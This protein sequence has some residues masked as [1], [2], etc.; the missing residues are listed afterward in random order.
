MDIESVSTGFMNLELGA[1]LALG[2]LAVTLFLLVYALLHRAKRRKALLERMPRL[3]FEGIDE[4]SVDEL[5]PD[6]F[7]HSNGFESSPSSRQRRDASR[8]VPL[9][10]QGRLEGHPV[11]VMDVSIHRRT[12][13]VTSSKDTTLSFDRTVLRCEMPAGSEAPDLLIEERVL[14]KSRVKGLRSIGGVEWFSEHYCVFSDASEA[15]LASWMSPPLQAALERIRSW[16]L[17]THDGVLFLQRT[18]RP[19]EPKE[20][21]SFLRE[22]GA[23][24][25]AFLSAAAPR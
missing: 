5:V 24:L 11:V 16:S 6:S 19:E 20:I 21:E 10:W 1:K 23:L 15:D 8:R 25:S 14:F 7:F 12:V 22:G 9:A 4:P 2:F 3:G 13:G 18:N 17:A